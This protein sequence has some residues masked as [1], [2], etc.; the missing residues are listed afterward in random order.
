MRTI[1]LL[2]RF[3]SSVVEFPVA[4][5]LKGRSVLFCFG[6]L[7][8]TSRR[9]FSPSQMPLAPSIPMLHIVVSYSHHE[10]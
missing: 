6:L 4:L 10:Q 3:Y 1:H 2:K 8:V 5:D 7:V 9:N